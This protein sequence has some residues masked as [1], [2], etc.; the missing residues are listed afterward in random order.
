MRG[1]KGMSP[2]MR[3]IFGLVLGILT[4][5][6]IGEPAGALSL[7]GDIYIRLLQMT[8]LPYV[9]VSLLD[10]INQSSFEHYADEIIIPYHQKK[11]AMASALTRLRERRIQTWSR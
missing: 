10:V 9:V 5:V 11:L 3:V 1:L 6:F 4:G 2:F 7:G 8:V